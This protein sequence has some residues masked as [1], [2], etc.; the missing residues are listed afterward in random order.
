MSG[1]SCGAN[2]RV[3]RIPSQ[4]GI[5]QRGN[6]DSCWVGTG[7]WAGLGW[8]LGWGLGVTLGVQ[9]AWPDRNV[10]GVLGEGAIMYGVQGLWSAVKY[11]IP[12]TIIVANNAQ[13]NIL[14]I[15]A[16]GMGLSGALEGQYEGMDLTSPEYD[17]VQLASSMGMRAVRVT[18]A[19]DL[20]DAIKESL[21]ISEPMLIDTPI[22]RETGKK[23]N[24]G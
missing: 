10:V 13:Y 9:M 21:A 14:K 19:D 12:A 7:C 6:L 17:L 16:Q 24:Y 18:T 5:C 15:C 11:Q 23:L 8:G 4:A 1:H 20:S 2:H 3:D 22:S